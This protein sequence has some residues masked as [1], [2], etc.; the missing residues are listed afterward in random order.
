[1][2]CPSCKTS[3]GRPASIGT[4]IRSGAITLWMRCRYCDHDWR[5][6]LPLTESK[7]DSGLHNVIKPK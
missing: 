6:N 4:T 7:S 1:M 2:E 5:F 3:A